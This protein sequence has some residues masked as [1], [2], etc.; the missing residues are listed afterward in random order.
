MKDL[1][2]GSTYETYGIE[3]GIPSFD[4]ARPI[5]NL[6]FIVQKDEND[7]RSCTLQI[8]FRNICSLKNDYQHTFRFN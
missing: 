1:K 8:L 4:A 2:D 7:S 5:L 6:I 3:I